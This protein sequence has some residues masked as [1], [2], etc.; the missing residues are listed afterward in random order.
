MTT[1]G[2]GDVLAGLTAGFFS[3]DEAFQSACAASFVNGFAG[4]L[5]YSEKTCTTP[6]QIF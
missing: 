3:K 2:T 6:L 5:V 4:D 1:G